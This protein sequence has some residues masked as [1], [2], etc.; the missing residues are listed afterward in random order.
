M[1]V[2]TIV[3]SWIDVVLT[4]RMKSCAA[5]ESPITLTILAMDSY[6]MDSVSRR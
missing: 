2:S 1:K 3:Q 6:Y 5:D 4:V